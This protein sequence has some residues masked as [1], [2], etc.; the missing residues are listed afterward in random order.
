[1]SWYP[2]LGTESVIDR[3]GHIRAVGWLSAA[4]PFRSG[5]VPFDFLKRLKEL[6]V[7]WGESTQALGWGIFMGSH[8]CELCGRFMSSGNLG[9]PSGDVLFVAPEMIPHYVEIHQYQPPDEFIAAV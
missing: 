3:G 8:E 1:M 4:H 6:A 5:D 9:V 7:R 2:D